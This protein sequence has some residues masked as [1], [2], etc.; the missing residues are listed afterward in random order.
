MQQYNQ[1]AEKEAEL[2]AQM[3][4]EEEISRK[5]QEE[6]YDSLSAQR[7]FERELESLRRQKKNELL[8]SLDLEPEPE[9]EPIQNAM[10]HSIVKKPCAVETIAQREERKRKAALDLEKQREQA[11]VDAAVAK[12]KHEIETNVALERQASKEVLESDRKEIFNVIR[13]RDYKAS[14]FRKGIG[15]SKHHKGCAK[16]G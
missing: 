5:K 3:E 13:A 7:Q 11:I 14:R 4:E 2:K 9:P 10:D 12:V 6:E 8:L 16:S 15:R 1:R